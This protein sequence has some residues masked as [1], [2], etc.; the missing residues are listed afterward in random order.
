[1]APQAFLDSL[2]FEHVMHALLPRLKAEVE[3]SEGDAAHVVS[4]QG[5]HPARWGT[6]CIPAR[7]THKCSC[8]GQGAGSCLVWFVRAMRMLHASLRSESGSNR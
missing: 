2:H 8:V 5:V 3:L 6:A 4:P 7:S 1:M